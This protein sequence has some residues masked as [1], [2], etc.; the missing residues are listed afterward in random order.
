M[1]ICPNVELVKE[2]M[3]SPEGSYPPDPVTGVRAP[4]WTPLHA[5][6][7]P[8]F[9][10]KQ[11]SG[12]LATISRSGTVV[13]LEAPRVDLPRTRIFGKA[14]LVTVCVVLMDDAV[15]DPPPADGSVPLTS[16][17]PKKRQLRFAPGCLLDEATSE[18]GGDV[19]SS[20]ASLSLMY[21]A[22]DKIS[23]KPVTHLGVVSNIPGTVSLKPF[24]EWLPEASGAP[25]GDA[26]GGSGGRGSIDSGGNSSSQWALQLAAYF[27]EQHFQLRANLMHSPIESDVLR[28]VQRSEKSKMLWYLVTSAMMVALRWLNRYR[29]RKMMGRLL[30]RAGADA[31]VAREAAWGERAAAAAAAASDSDDLVDDDVAANACA[32]KRVETAKDNVQRIIH[33]DEDAYGIPDGLEED[34]LLLWEPDFDIEAER[35]FVQRMLNT[36]E[37]EWLTQGDS[38]AMT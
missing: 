11:A 23:T 22:G 32:D 10:V 21:R 27:E 19:E 12:D 18:E 16:R 33:E 4:G 29:V 20:R 2:I 15:S 6:Y 31:A 3:S 17:P 34:S 37:E 35:D 24:F 14:P 25:E 13:E 38:R 30:G 28:M 1:T 36:Y 26:T 8:T 9:E 5:M 7:C